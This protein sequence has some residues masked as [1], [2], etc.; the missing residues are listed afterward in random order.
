[1]L[2][3]HSKGP[4]TVYY[5]PA[6]GWFSRF[7]NGNYLLQD[8][9]RT[10]RSNRFDWIK[11]R[12]RKWIKIRNRK[13]GKSNNGLHYRLKQLGLVPNYLTTEQKKK[14]GDSCMQLLHFHCT[15]NW[16]NNLVIEYGVYIKTWPKTRTDSIRN[17]SEHSEI[18]PIISR[19]LILYTFR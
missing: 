9:Q 17:N 2:R 15:L 4:R 5:T 14:Q 13:L 11:E 10:R 6:K 1:M 8:D 18:I 19:I 12:P 3:K 7:R 16:L